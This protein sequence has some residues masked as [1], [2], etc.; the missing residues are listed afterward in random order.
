MDGRSGV[1]MS[2]QVAMFDFITDLNTAD[3]KIANPDDSQSESNMAFLVKNEGT[4]E[5]TLEVIPA[6]APEGADYQENKFYP[7]WNPELIRAIKTNTNTLPT[8]KYGY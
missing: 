8:L 4:S 6:A 1:M 2:E 7:G 5:V 3:F